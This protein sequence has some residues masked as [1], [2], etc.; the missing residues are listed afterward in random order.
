L[1][2]GTGLRNKQKSSLFMSGWECSRISLWKSAE[3]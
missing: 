2:N 1:A 3:N